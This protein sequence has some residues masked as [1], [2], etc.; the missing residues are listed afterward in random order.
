V[1][2]IVPRFCAKQSPAAA[3]EKTRKR[4]S[5]LMETLPERTVA[6]DLE[7]GSIYYNPPGVTEAAV[8]LLS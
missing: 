3:S 2:R 4:R 7:L 6:F 8:L 1:P 5:V